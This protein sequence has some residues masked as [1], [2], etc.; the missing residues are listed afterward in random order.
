MSE[1]RSNVKFTKNHFMRWIMTLIGL[2]GTLHTDE[3]RSW[4]NYPLSLMREKILKFK[5]EIICGE[6]RPED[7]NEY[8]KNKT[9]SGYLGPSEYRQTIIPLCEEYGIPFWPIDDFLDEHVKLDH[10]APYSKEE[11]ER[12]SSELMN[13][14]EEIF[15]KA[16]R[17]PIPF[18]SYQLNQ[19]IEEKQEWLRKVNP[20]VQHTVWDER[21]EKLI[22]NIKKVVEEN[23]GKR[24][25]VTIGAEHGYV[26]LK[27]F[28]EFRWNVEFPIG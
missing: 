24:I 16:K 19:L 23:E 1:E 9:Y 10:F 8:Q 3:T 17:D 21:N 25:L 6:V 14:Y 22:V 27:A 11:Q 28:Q 4:A 20:E 13:R 15:E 7:W 12:L 18:N 2:L 26:F 5:P